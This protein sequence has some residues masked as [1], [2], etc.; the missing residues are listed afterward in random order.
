[1]KQ[2]AREYGVNPSTIE[3][4]YA[5]NWLLMALS[6]LP[7]VLKGGTGIRKVYISN[8]RFSDDLDF[9]LLEEFSAEEFKA[10][11]DKV[12]EKAREESG[13][14]FFDDSGFRENDNGFEID[15]YFQF[16]QRGEN[17][18]KIKLDITKAKNE[19][20]LLPVLRE[21]IIHLYSDDLDCEVKVYSLEEIVAEKIRSL[22]Q[23]T[24][25][26]DLYDVWYLWSKTNDIDRRKVLKILPEKFKEKGVVVDIQD[27]ENRKNDFR[28]AWEIS[29]GHQL[30]ELPDFET[31]F[32][33]VLQEV[34]TMCVEMIRSSKDMILNG[35][36]CALLHDI[37]K[38]H[39]NFIKTQ[40]VEDIKGLPHHSGGI[41]QLIKAE[42]V[43]SF[44]SI[45]M[46]INTES[47]SIY[48]SIRFHHDNSTNNILKCLKECDRKDSADDKGIVRRKQHLD[49]T[50]ISSPFGHPKEKIDLNCL[51]KIF[52]DLQDELIELFKNYRSLDA[53]HLRSN[54][55]NILKTPFSHALGETRIPANDVTLWDHSYSTASLFKSVLAAITCGTNPNPQDLKWRIFAICWNGMEFINKGKKV[56]EIQSRND[57]IENLKKKL[58]GIFEEEIPVGNV[59][60][61]D[62]NG[63]Y[64]TFPD[65]NRACDLAEECAKIALETIQKET[66]NELWPFFIL[67]EATQTLTIIANVQRSAFEK[68]KV[69]KMTPVLFVE[70][71]ERY[72]EN[73]DLP[74]FTVRQSICPVCG[75][76]PRDEGKERCK[77]CYKRRQGRLSK[78]LSNRE[79]TIWIDEV[80][81][82]NNKIALISLNFYLDKWLDGTMVGT[83]YSQTFED[84]LN[85]ERS[86]L[87][88]TQKKHLDGIENKIDKLKKEIEGMKKAKDPERAK[89]KIAKNL[90]Q[91][92]YLNQKK[93]EFSFLLYPNKETV[94][95]VLDMFFE[96]MNSNDNNDKKT[97]VKILS[98]FFEENINLNENTIE[99]HL[100]NIK[101]RIGTDQLNREN[102][103]T[104]LFTHNPSPARLY[105]IWRE[106][107]EFIGLVVEE[108]KNTVYSTKWNRVKFTV[109]ANEFSKLKKQIEP[110]T[111]Y[112]IRM[113]NLEPSDLLVFHNENG[114]FYTI[115]SLEK[116]RFEDKAGLEAIKSALMQGIRHIELEEGSMNS[117]NLIKSGE[118]LQVNNL[119]E[120]EYYPFI[121]INSSPLSLRLIIPAQDSMKIVSLVTDLYNEM[122]ERV[123]GKLPLDIKLLVTKRKFPVYLLL[124]AESRMLEDEEFTK[125]LAMN[126]WWNI[127]RHDEFYGFYPADSIEHG[128]K[129]T[130]DHL[131]PISKGKI[132]YLYPG[133]FDF[134]LLSENTDRYNIAYSKEEKI[135]RADEIY[136]LFTERP[137]YF[138]KISEILELWDVLTNLTSSQIHFVEEALTLKI[139]EWREVK[140]RENVFMNFAEATLKDAFNN[141]WDKLREETK[142][143]LL[144][145]ACNGLLLDTI[146]LFKRTLA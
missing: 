24:R 102:L 110:Q 81:D 66:Q 98:T 128:K 97:A 54:L 62:M 132:F 146:N 131:N 90:E 130:I 65:L 78:W 124:D 106:T 35:E 89:E 143:F 21:K 4:D 73:P 25:P 99:D 144:K 38:L 87:D 86:E 105:R 140:D 9:T 40:S 46:K 36:I 119:T 96:A 37:G 126:P 7:L 5:Q 26:R 34:K 122:F 3:R 79:E 55:I 60:F 116:Y 76:R 58:T 74:S 29:L 121:E 51:Q 44:K 50:W 104:F 11:I 18:T 129:Y 109:D 2:K 27:L 67:S 47:M 84:W 15:I 80:A 63:I 120:E 95:K 68:R 57:V 93:E 77:I 123:I 133:Y 8:Y 111:P 100:N 48:D 10:T 114:E 33:I 83:I 64:F 19:R 139:R 52:D 138:Y 72:L 23:R 13:M 32:S 101:E 31:V 108:M 53:K 125:Q 61:E 85:K 20:I 141:K 113:K 71:K 92:K 12:I 43:N 1:M 88:K 145:S 49:S 69:P 16:M 56:A 59:V 135:K 17:R 107:E 142:W 14:N 30:K 117:K 28:N 41:D 70:D 112:I 82:K 42:L 115:E 134:D 136:R 118:C 103:A 91:I 39:P 6:S 22:F 94:Y 75:I 127:K 137:Y 45:D